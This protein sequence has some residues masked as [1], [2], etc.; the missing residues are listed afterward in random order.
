VNYIKFKNVSD[1][2]NNAVGSSLQGYIDEVT[3][4]QL[5]AMFGEP[6]REQSG[7]GKV[8]LEWIIKTEI[9]NE[10][11]DIEEGLFTL[12]DWKGSAP[13]NDDIEWRINVGGKSKSDYFN[14]F[15]AFDIANQTDFL[16]AY[17]GDGKLIQE[18]EGFNLHLLDMCKKEAANG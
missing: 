8:N 13:S 7:D 16:Y 5:I 1:D 15:D 2:W 9:I 17:E 3:T 14:V 6:S 10:D 11:G 12:Y 18:K 4:N